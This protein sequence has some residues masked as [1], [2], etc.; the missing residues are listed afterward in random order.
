[1]MDPNSHMS[2]LGLLE[3]VFPSL[4]RVVLYAALEV[5][6]GSL[7]VRA[8]SEAPKQLVDLA[9]PYRRRLSCCWDREMMRTV[10]LLVAW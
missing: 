3:A 2:A 6:N 7:E 10:H 5:A 8:T 9:W 4:P 1:M